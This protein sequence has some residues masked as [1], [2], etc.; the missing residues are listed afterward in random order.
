MNSVDERHVQE[1]AAYP[2]HVPLV[3]HPTPMLIRRYKK[4]MK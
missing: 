2:A 4:E 1:N 3:Q